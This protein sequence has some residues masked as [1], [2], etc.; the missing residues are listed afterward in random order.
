MSRKIIFRDKLKSH[1]KSL[2]KSLGGLKGEIIFGKGRKQVSVYNS[3]GI[4]VGY[5]SE[6]EEVM[7]RDENIIPI[8]GYQY[9][10]NKLFNIGLDQETTLRVGDLNDEAPLMKIGVPRAEYKS[11]HYNAEMS[12]GVAGLNPMSGINI[13]GNHFIFGFMIGDGASKEDN[14]TAIAPNYKDR[15]LFRP[16]PFRM[17][18]D[19]FKMPDAKY[20]GKAISAPNNNGE[21]ITSYYIKRFDDPKPHIIHSYVSDNPNELQ[22]VDDTVFF[23]TSSTPIES[24]VEINF[25]LSQYDCRNYFTSTDSTPRISEIGLVAGWYNSEK[26]DF[27]QIRLISHYTRPAILLAENDELEGIYRIYAR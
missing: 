25:S 3:S 17:S 19:N 6:F 22:I 16:I 15:V 9:V 13:S 10:F 12:T 14:V 11:I 24:Y 23:S 20:Y 5:K 18:N 21:R 27:E 26:D 1:D 2:N 4:I 7:D 8:G